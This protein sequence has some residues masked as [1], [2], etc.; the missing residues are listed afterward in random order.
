MTN[1][2][3][4]I[5]HTYNEESNIKDCIDSA[6]LLS[7]SI[8][9][10]DMESTDETVK[11]AKKEGVTIYSFPPAQYVEPAR[12]FGIGKASTDW[13][14][15]LDA[16]ERL[17]QALADEMKQS[18]VTD[19]FTHYKVS[20]KE[21]YFKKYWLSHTGY[22]PNYQI[23][24]INKKYFKDW[25]KAIHSTPMIEGRLGQLK[26]AMIHFSKNDFAS[27]VDKTIV[28][29][30][31][32]SNLLFEAGRDVSVPIFF[33]KYFGELYRRLI[34]NKGIL[35]GKIGIV[36]SLYQAYSKTITNLYLYEKKKSRSL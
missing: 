26:E 8:V 29:E 34:K 9:V 2:I 19:D 22:W 3:S 1:T 20:R 27:M 5:I 13:V 23:R 31:K 35:D 30:D 21:M 6:R 10:I 18:M 16:D 25:P 24:F 17:T 32:E 7:D 12:G 14:F 15:I 11:I 4:V 28:Y 36:E 33:K